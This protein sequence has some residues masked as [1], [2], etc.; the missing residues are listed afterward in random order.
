MNP[1][2]P[3]AKKDAVYFSGHKFLGGPGSSGVLIVKRFIL[4]QA[5]EPPSVPGGGTVFYVTNDHHRYLTEREEREE[6]GSPQLLGDVKLAL[7]MN[8]MR[9]V[10]AQ[11]IAT[12]EEQ[13]M[14]QVQTAF[15]ADPRIVVLG[16]QG[17]AAAATGRRWW[18]DHR[19]PPTRP[20]TRP[21]CHRP[22]QMS[23]AMAPCPWYPPL[24]DVD[25]RIP[26][27]PGPR[28]VRCTPNSPSRWR[29]PPTSRPA[30]A[31]RR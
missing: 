14:T 11:T 16:H 17:A 23:P 1:V 2:N 8:L 9:E 26:R 25:V 30:P 15:Q 21:L 24:D 3:L 27:P 18:T 20:A 5:F 12:R 6:G 13:I 19:L 31:N 10:G 29:K 22:A 28:D 7:S 4:P